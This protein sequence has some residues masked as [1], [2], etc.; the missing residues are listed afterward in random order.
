MALI[1]LNL[2][3]V[4]E[5]RIA[6]VFLLLHSIFFLAVFVMDFSPKF[7]TC[8]EDHMRGGIFSQC[9]FF[10]TLPINENQR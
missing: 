10:Q 2:F 5:S 4:K 3:L 6:D 8:Q 7:D 9:F 1:F